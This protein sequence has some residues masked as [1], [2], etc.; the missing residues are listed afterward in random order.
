MTT[1][2]SKT[3]LA[4]QRQMHE[5]GNYGKHGDK[6]ADE[7]KRLH[8]KYKCNDILDFG[9]GRGR[10]AKAL[11]GYEVRCYDPAVPKFSA[12][13]E[14]ADLVVSSDVMEH[15]EPEY[16]DNVLDYI[17]SLTRK[18]FFVVI[19]T[20]AAVKNLPDGRNC[21]ILLRDRNWWLDALGRHKFAVD[22]VTES[23]KEEI[24]AVLRPC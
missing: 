16:I 11:R 24:I 5:E 9:A 12:L 6:W 1:Y 23:G 13:P 10:L 2:I 18:V 7:V 15:I 20:R 21:H 4:L 17:R 8:A 3:Y 22:E 14:P 19:A